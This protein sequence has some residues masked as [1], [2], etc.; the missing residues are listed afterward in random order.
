MQGKITIDIH[1]DEHDFME[2]CLN[3]RHSNYDPTILILFYALAQKW[4]ITKLNYYLK[5]LK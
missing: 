1:L 5:L 2:A 4:H 3:L